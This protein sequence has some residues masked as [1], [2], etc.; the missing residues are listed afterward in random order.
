MDVSTSSSTVPVG[1]KDGAER[2][3]GDIEDGVEV[4]TSQA[5]PAPE[6]IITVRQRKTISFVEIMK[7][8]FTIYPKRSILCLILF[9]GQAFLCNGITFNLVT[10]FHGFYGV[11]M[12]NVPIFIYLWSLSDFAGPVTLDRHLCAV[13][14]GVLR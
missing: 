1:Q 2:I 8:A 14:L 10:L 12:A 9:V 5:L 3:V 11:A 13:A 4:E 7:V 6:K